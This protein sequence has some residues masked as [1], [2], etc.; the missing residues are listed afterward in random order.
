MTGRLSPLRT[1]LVRH[2]QLYLLVAVPL[3][4]IVV[5]QYIPMAGAQIAFRDFNV[6]D[7]FWRSPWVGLKHFREFLSS[8]IFAEIFRNTLVLSFYQLVA[9]FPMP[10]I[11]ALAL[12]S[13]QSQ[14]FKKSV[15]FV[16]YAP[17]FISTVVIVSMI[18]LL[19]AP[20][21]GVVENIVGF[22]G[23]HNVNLMGS[24]SLFPSIYVWSGVWQNTGYGAVVYLAA[25]AG[26]DPQLYEAA[27]MDGATR[28]QRVIHIDFPTILPTAVVLLILDAGQIMNVGFEKVYLMQNPA[29]LGTSEIIATY[30]YKIGLLGANFSYSAA[31]GLL[32]SIVNLLILVGVNTAARRLSE[33]SLW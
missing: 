33:F 13:T 4:F 25:L 12:N 10:I 7:G 28:F 24:P 3:T 32:N 9:G 1:K 31:I 27:I 2:W 8:P 17:Y 14:R 30:V 5:F 16:T 23:Y 19:L 11:L 18:I 15:Q 21:G 20:R 29:N 22:L 6:Q 26:V